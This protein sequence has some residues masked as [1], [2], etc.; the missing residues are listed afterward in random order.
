M[1]ADRCVLAVDGGNTKT[2]AVVADGRRTVLGAAARARGHLQRASP[3]RRSRRS[4]PRSRRG[5]RG[6]RAS[7]RRPRRRGLQP[8]RRRLARGL[9]PARARAARAARAAR[10]AGGRQ[11]RAGRRCAAGRAGLGRR[12]GRRR[13]LQRDRRAERR[14]RHLPPRLLAR[15]RRR[16]ATRPATALRA[17]LPRRMLDLGP[18]TVAVERALA[19]YGTDDAIACCTSSRAAAGLPTPTERPVRRRS[20]STRPTRATSSPATI[21]RREGRAVLGEL[22]R[23]SA[24]TRAGLPLE[25]RSRSSSPARVLAHPTPLL[26]RRDRWRGCPAPIA[27][28]PDVDARRRRASA[29]R[30]TASA[31]ARPRRRRARGRA[32]PDARTRP[33]GGIA[34][35]RVTKVY[36]RRRHGRRRRLRSRSSDGEFMVLVGPSGCGKSTLLRMIAGLEERHRPGRSGSATATSPSSRRATATSRWCSRTTRSTPT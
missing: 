24:P 19:L 21:V 28:Y 1:V 13:H 4:W 18:P 3:S 20:S 30:S 9:R 11:R 12:R 35:E 31:P 7:R 32:R 22:R 6:R 34:L 5:A 27:V 15:R 25:G 26:A 33:M 14:R 36:P 29:R 16:H 8:R 10:D 23:A 2:I 17:D